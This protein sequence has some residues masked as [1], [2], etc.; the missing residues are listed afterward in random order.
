[1]RVRL[2]RGAGSAGGSI[3]TPMAAMDGMRVLASPG[4]G[5]VDVG[6]RDKPSGMTLALPEMC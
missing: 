1:M 4:L 3:G 5:G 2:G 6:S